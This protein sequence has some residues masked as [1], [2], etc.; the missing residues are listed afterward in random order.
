MKQNFKEYK[1]VIDE[2]EKKYLTNKNVL[3]TDLGKV[4]LKDKD[5]GDIAF[6][7]TGKKFYII[8]PRISDIC[9]KMERR[10]SIILKKDIG[11]VIAYTGLGSGDMVVDAGTGSGNAAIYFANIVKPHGK[12]YTYE[13]REEF[14]KIALRNFK[15]AGVDKF[16]ELK[17]KNIYFGIDEENIDMIFFDLPEP[18][19]AIPHA[20]KALNVGGF[21]AIYNP[22]VE[23][24]KKTVFSLKK[25]GFRMI[26]TYEIIE[27]EIEVKEEGVR[28]VTKGLLHTAYITFARKLSKV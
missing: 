3:L 14:A 22:Y 17:L 28:P 4:Y 25:Y 10:T 26:R 5:F 11:F 23:Q 16:I 20:F 2:R 15:I 27:R 9:E 8:K 6:S 24:V 12:V 7:N 13:I 19:K 1:L 21:I 18:W